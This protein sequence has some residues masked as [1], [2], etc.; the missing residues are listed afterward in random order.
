MISP[1]VRGVE[2]IKGT[3]CS[4]RD[5][6]LALE[7]TGGLS[8]VILAHTD[9]EERFNGHWSAYPLLRAL[10]R[11]SRASREGGEHRERTVRREGERK[12]ACEGCCGSEIKSGNYLEQHD[13]SNTWTVSATVVLL[14]PGS[15]LFS[16]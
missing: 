8:P 2:T 7:A 10:R 13:S 12:A 5:L 6:I 15:I 9:A 4:S 1:P 3:P 14:W 16:G 11:R